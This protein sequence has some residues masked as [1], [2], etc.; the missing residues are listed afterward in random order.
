MCVCDPLIAVFMRYTVVEP[1]VIAPPPPRYTTRGVIFQSR[2]LLRALLVS[3][4]LLF[5]PSFH[6]DIFLLAWENIICSSSLQLQVPPPPDVHYAW[7][8]ANL[9]Y[10]KCYNLSPFFLL[11]VFFQFQIIFGLALQH[12]DPLFFVCLVR[13]F[14]LLV[15]LFC[16][17]RIRLP[18]SG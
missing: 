7:L 18:G 3:R 11:L 16:H 8:P 17:R 1:G 14:W 5:Y 12:H 2:V 4:P 15:V 9:Q 13:V 6:F 10:F